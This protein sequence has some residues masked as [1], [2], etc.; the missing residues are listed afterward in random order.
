MSIKRQLRRLA[1][2]AEDDQQRREELFNMLMSKDANEIVAYVTLMDDVS[3]LGVMMMVVHSTSEDVAARKQLLA[4]FDL[5]LHDIDANED[6]WGQLQ[7]MV[8]VESLTPGDVAKAVQVVLDASEDTHQ[9]FVAMLTYDLAR[10]TEDELVDM[11]DAITNGM[12]A[13]DAVDYIT[14]LTQLNA[15]DLTKIAVNSLHGKQQL[16]ALM[17]LFGITVYD[18]T[19]P[20][21]M[22]ELVQVVAD[23]RGMTQ[24]EAT[25]YIKAEFPDGCLAYGKPNAYGVEFFDPRSTW[26]DQVDYLQPFTMADAKAVMEIAFSDGQSRDMFAEILTNMFDDNG[27]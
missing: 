10:Y 20:D 18:P 26:Y 23:H 13:E 8:D 14:T 1:S 7:R 15:I 4:L 17:D 16:R 19:R 6:A 24:E 2:A 12:S 21:E 3:L 11:Y 5:T 9:L 25:A 22:A 27:W